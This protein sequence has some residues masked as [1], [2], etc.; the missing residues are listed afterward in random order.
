ME[1][2]STDLA[3]VIGCHLAECFV[4]VLEIVGLLADEQEE[5]VFDISAKDLGSCLLCEFRNKWKTVASN[6]ILD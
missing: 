1:V 2:S 6:E 3:L 5:M 4:L